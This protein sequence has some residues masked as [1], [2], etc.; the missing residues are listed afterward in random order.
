[1]NDDNYSLLMPKDHHVFPAFKFEYYLSEWSISIFT[2]KLE[3][4]SKFASRNH[5]QQVYC[6]ALH[7]ANISLFTMQTT[8]R[9]DCLQPKARK[10]VYFN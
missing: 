4:P 6:I 10:E 5:D 7:E 9:V 3:Y 1:M 8:V 2:P